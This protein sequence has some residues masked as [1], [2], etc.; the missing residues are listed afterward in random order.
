MISLILAVGLFFLPESPRWF[1]KKGRVDAAA[2][3]LA[4]IRGQ[5]ADSEYIQSELA[6]IVA[7]HEYETE[8]M[9]TGGYFSSW[10]ACFS[11]SLRNPASN[12]RKTILG[13]SI[14]VSQRPLQNTSS[15]VSSQSGSIGGKCGTCFPQH[16]LAPRRDHFPTILAD[17]II[18]DAAAHRCQL[19]LLLW[20]VLL[21]R[22]D[23][24]PDQNSARN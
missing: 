20:H 7:N 1:V 22:P 14:Q 17:T 3:A 8:L 18:D 2:A 6:E 4:R 15:R 19:H 11:G 23:S 12:L 5:P 16:H 9:P 24:K 13:T 10:M 21:V